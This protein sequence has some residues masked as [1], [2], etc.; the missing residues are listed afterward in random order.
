MDTPARIVLVALIW[1][2]IVFVAVTLWRRLANQA[3]ASGRL[4][5]QTEPSGGDDG[6]RP[7]WLSRRLALAGF[8]SPWAGW[9]LIAATLG[10]LG[11]GVMLAVMFRRSGLQR[12]VLEGVQAVPGGLSGML[13][14]VV[15]VA[16]WLITVLA[17]S[18][19]VLWVRAARRKR[20]AEV[21]RDLPLALDLWATLSEGGLGFDA[22]LDRW[23]KTQ[24]PDRVLAKACRGFQ[25]DL[26]G[27]MRRSEAYRRL[28]MRLDVPGLTRFTAAMIQSEQT[29][30]R[31]SE[32][33]RLQADD[34]R[35]VRR[36]KSL[37]FAQS[38]A[39]KRVIPLVICFLP[40]LFVWPLGPFFTQLLRIVDQLVAGGESL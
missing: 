27:G 13:S 11:V 17:A 4:A 10:M 5:R 31:V 21:T 37:A 35:V 39:T 26:L 32:T 19:P 7:G 6:P 33:L 2:S 12:A 25:R 29:G 18:V 9:L 8:D 36:E 40:G 22:A 20:V 28:A 16:P 24:R 1:G 38:L 23:Q 30:S 34:V 3:E 15:I 14:P